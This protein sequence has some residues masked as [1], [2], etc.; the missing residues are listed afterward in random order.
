MKLSKKG[1]FQ[2]SIKVVPCIRGLVWKILKKGIFLIGLL[3]PFSSWAKGNPRGTCD[4]FID[5]G[6]GGSDLGG[7]YLELQEKDLSLSWAQA[8]AQYLSNQGYRVQLSRNQDVYLGLE[9]RAKMFNQSPC[10]R[11]LSIHINSHTDS[12][13]KGTEIITPKLPTPPFKPIQ[14]PQDWQRILWEIKREKLFAQ[15]YSWGKSLAEILRNKLKRP[16]RVYASPLKILNQSEKPAL[17]LEIAYLSNPED[18]KLILS[19]EFQ[20]QF[21]QALEMGLF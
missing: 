21:I 2:L 20:T 1:L 17:V 19:P 6:H 8:W 18:Q 16:T 14:N 5:P 13:L 9:E 4:L 10:P 3:S 7:S 12:K 11:M 15:P